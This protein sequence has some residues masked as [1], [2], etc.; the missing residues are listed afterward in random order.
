MTVTSE[1]AVRSSRVIGQ[2]V[3][4]EI[5]SRTRASRT[6]DGKVGVGIIL[7]SVVTVVTA[8]LVTEGDG[9]GDGGGDG[10]RIRDGRTILLTVPPP[11]TESGYVLP[12]TTDVEYSR[13]IS[14]SHVSGDQRRAH[15]RAIS[16]V[17]GD[18][19]RE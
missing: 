12:A 17:P 6:K 1:E 7:G 8:A 19:Y 3:F 10:S 18:T 2:V 14:V 5:A 4:R 16:G 9:D 15:A 13:A 11:L